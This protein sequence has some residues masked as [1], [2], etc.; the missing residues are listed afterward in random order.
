MERFNMDTNKSIYKAID[1]LKFLAAICVVAI[2]TN[3]FKDINNG[4]YNFLSYCIFTFAVPFFFIIS[5]FFLFLSSL[6]IFK[7]RLFI[8]KT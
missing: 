3:A 8:N 7:E 6:I 1:I 2:H 5:G 4:I